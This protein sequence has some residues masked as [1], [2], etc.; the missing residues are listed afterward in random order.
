MHPHKFEAAT[1]NKSKMRAMLG[2]HKKPHTNVNVI[3]APK[4]QDQPVPVPVPMAGPSAPR[5]PPPSGIPPAAPVPFPAAAGGGGGPPVPGMVRKSGGRVD[6]IAGR[7]TK[8]WSR[9]SDENSQKYT[10][11]K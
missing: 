6:Y 5:L 9:R 2:E 3:V 7:D 8:A 4:G 11:G 10:K 1:S